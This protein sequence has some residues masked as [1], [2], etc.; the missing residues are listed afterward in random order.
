MFNRKRYNQW[1][2][3]LDLWCKKHNISREQAISILSDDSSYN[4]EDPKKDLITIRDLY[5]SE[6]DDFCQEFK[7]EKKKERSL[8]L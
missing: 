7:E 8:S 6:M 2:E 1:L 4:K 3:N 5:W